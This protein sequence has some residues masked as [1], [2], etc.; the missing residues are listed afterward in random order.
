[1]KK[2]ARNLVAVCAL[3][4]A[5]AGLGHAV[6]ISSVTSSITPTPSLLLRPHESLTYTLSGTFAGRAVLEKSFD[7]T[8]YSVVLSSTNNSNA[9]LTGTQYTDDQGAYYRWRASTWTSGA[10]IFGLSDNNDLVKEFRNNKDAVIL[11]LKDD[12]VEVIGSLIATEPLA[13]TA[14]TSGNSTGRSIKAYLAGATPAVEGS[15]LVATTPVAGTGPI[16]TEGI[17]VIVSPATIDLTNWVGIAKAATSTG[18]IVDVYYSGF[19]L[20]R[21]TGTVVAGD[22]L[23]STGTV[24]GYLGADATPTTGADVGVAMTAGNAAGGLTKIRLK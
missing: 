20:A 10:F 18:S 8:N 9:T 21:T 7:G 1:M 6:V 12:S 16:V 4:V 5:G 15:L 14:T 17:S 23:V 3:L 24:A 11:R 22:T 19:V 13:S 2:I